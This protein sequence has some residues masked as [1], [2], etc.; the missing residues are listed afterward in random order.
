MADSEGTG[1]VSF[2][3]PSLIG[4]VPAHINRVYMPTLGGIIVGLPADAVNTGIGIYVNK[5]LQILNAVPITITMRS[6]QPLVIPD[7]VLTLDLE[8]SIL[9]DD[10][11]PDWIYGRAFLFFAGT[12]DLTGHEGALFIVDESSAKTNWDQLADLDGLQ[13]DASLVGLA[14]SAVVYGNASGSGEVS[15]AAPVVTGQRV[16][17]GQRGA[18]GRPYSIPIDPPRPVP[19][20]NQGHGVVRFPVA[21]LRGTSRLVYVNRGGVLVEGPR[22]DGT[23]AWRLSGVG[24][25]RS[26]A[27][28]MRGR[29]SVIL[30]RPPRVTV[31]APSP[32]AMRIQGTGAIALSCRVVASAHATTPR[33]PTPLPDVALL[34]LQDEAWLLSLLDEVA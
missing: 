16:A 34:A 21:S 30:R 15:I 1:A 27:V 17:Y 24:L 2:D 33:C 8:G 13:M 29:G 23:G 14:Q 11:P 3:A 32:A 25:Q 4:G 10:Y 28:T 7:V 20:A 9:D 6:L 26:T 22:L 12:V 5:P 31:R 18:A 19:E